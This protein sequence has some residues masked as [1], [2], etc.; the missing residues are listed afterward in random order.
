MS[1]LKLFGVLAIIA[2]ASGITYGGEK[3]SKEEPAIGIS[4]E[5]ARSRAER[6]RDLR[7]RVNFAL[8]PGAEL[9]EGSTEINVTL[10]KHEIMVVDFKWLVYKES[11]FNGELLEVK[12]NGRILKKYRQVNGHILI[13]AEALRSGE[14]SLAFRFKTP[15]L[16]SGAAI[17]R[18]LDRDDKSEYL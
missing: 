15:A 10:D 2:I 6:Y 1:Y 8:V 18:Y 14:N 13:P 7:Y 11:T 12:A 3:L 4:R 5:L 17:T 9:L 16:K